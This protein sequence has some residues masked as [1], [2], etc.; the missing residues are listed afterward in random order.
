[1][2]FGETHMVYDSRLSQGNAKALNE[3]ATHRATALHSGLHSQRE[4]QFPVVN[5]VGQNA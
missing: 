1:M 4:S 5:K 3:W 2:G